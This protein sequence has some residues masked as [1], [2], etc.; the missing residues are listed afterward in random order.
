MAILKPYGAT[1]DVVIAKLTREFLVL[2][3]IENVFRCPVV[4]W[5]GTILL[6]DFVYFFTD[7][8]WYFI[9]VLLR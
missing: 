5:A 9:F 4:Y 7:E 6:D 2:V 3:A 1:V 8:G